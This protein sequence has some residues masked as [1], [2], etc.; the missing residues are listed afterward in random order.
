M[1]KRADA[2]VDVIEAAMDEASVGFAR[3]K[4]VL[5]TKACTGVTNTGHTR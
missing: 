4:N 5:W 1:K 2:T 3:P